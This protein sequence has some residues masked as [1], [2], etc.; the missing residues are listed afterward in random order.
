MMRIRVFYTVHPRRGVDSVK[1]RVD[2]REFEG[3]LMKKLEKTDIG[4]LL[5]RLALGAVF[6]AHGLQKFFPAQFGGGGGIEGFTKMLT[7]L[8][9]PQPQVMAYI[10][11]ACELGGGALVVLG[12]FTR[13]GALAIVG[14]MTVAF[15]KVHMR[16]GF[17]APAGFEYVMV[18]GA[19]ALALVVAGA[20]SMGADAMI[21]TKGPKKP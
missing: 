16:N 6:V 12:L 4:L 8:D 14:V 18:L 21:G 15:V 20:G 17:F 13:I 10:T 11:A 7:D 3:D 5:I 19:A 2:R 1:A 9:V